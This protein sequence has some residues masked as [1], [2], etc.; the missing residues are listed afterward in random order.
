MG[1]SLAG[2]IGAVAGTLV[3]AINYYLFV[4]ILDRGARERE[5]T[6]SPGERDSYDRKMS[7]V[8]RLVLTADLVV[9]AGAGYWFGRSFFE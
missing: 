5:L 6:Q 3:A 2:L 7:V 1:I 9:F 4:A 8:R